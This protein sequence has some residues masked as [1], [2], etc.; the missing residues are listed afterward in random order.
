M[1]RSK[2]SENGNFY[3]EQNIQETL[4]RGRKRSLGLESIAMET[5][6]TAKVFLQKL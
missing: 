6:A 1:H 3:E 4:L 2:I 5:H